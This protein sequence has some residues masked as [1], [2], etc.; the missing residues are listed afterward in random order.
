MP[1]SC[2]CAAATCRIEGLCDFLKLQPNPAMISGTGF[3]V[4]TVSQTQH[5]KVGSA[6]DHLRIH[7]WRQRL[8]SRQIELFEFYVGYMLLWHDYEPMFAV[9]REPTR[10]ENIREGLVDAFSP[11]WK[12]LHYK[13]RHR[14]VRRSKSAPA[15]F[16]R[17]GRHKTPSLAE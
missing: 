16:A 1:L 9:P 6:P 2:A 12:R 4:P 8:S 7:A 11:Y 10:W 13:L 14:H 15:Q 3:R 5:A 17:L